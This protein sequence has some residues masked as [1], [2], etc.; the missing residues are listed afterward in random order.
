MVLGEVG[1][2]DPAP[3]H[4]G[5]EHVGFVHRAD[6][7]AARLGGDGGDLGDALDLGGFV[8]HRVDGL[9]FAVFEQRGG[10]GLA[11]VD[12][13][14]QLANADDVDAVGDA[15]GLE[16]RGVGEIRIQQTGADVRKE[17]K[18]LAQREQSS[19][20]GL[21]LGGKFLPL[22]AADGAEENGVGLLAEREGGVG[23]GFAVIVDACAADVGVL[24][25]EV[26]AL[27]FGDVGENA[28]RLGHD[29]GTDVV[30]GQD[31]KFKGGHGRMKRKTLA[32]CGAGWQGG[33][34]QE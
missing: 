8:N 21:L 32:R 29:F 22:G 30:T 16:R 1:G 25:I 23:Q 5:F 2:D 4:G 27:L 24:V 34:G 31:G 13:A 12:A 20:L 14:G 33:F 3:E 11:E 9:L 26:Q 10:L 28:E 18:G 15:G 6:F 17:V 19:A 7:F